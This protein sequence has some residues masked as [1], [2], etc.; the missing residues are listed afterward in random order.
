MKQIASHLPSHRLWIAPSALAA[1][2]LL[3]FAQLA[4][5][6]HLICC[7]KGRDGGLRKMGAVEREGAIY[8]LGSG[9]NAGIAI[10]LV[11]AQK[12]HTSTKEV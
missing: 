10:N 9:Q 3:A 2:F 12:N 11:S 5:R 6:R 8:Q 1:L 7:S 4:S